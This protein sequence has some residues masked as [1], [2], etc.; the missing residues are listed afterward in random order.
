MSPRLEVPPATCP[1]CSEISRRAGSGQRQ[2]HRARLLGCVSWG[3]LYGGG[4]CEAADAGLL[5]YSHGH[6]LFGEPGP[7][8]IAGQRRFGFCQTGR[9]VFGPIL[10]PL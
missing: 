7:I 2:E 3:A 6:G 8:A 4:V 5:V 1:W 10:L 9:P